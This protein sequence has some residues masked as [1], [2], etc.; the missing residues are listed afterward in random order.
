MPQFDGN[1]ALQVTRELT[2]EAP[3]I[4]VS[5]TIGE[6]RAIDALRAGAADYVLKDNLLRL[7]PAVRRAL[8]D[9][10]VRQDRVRQEE[11][12]ARLDRV[13]GMLSG[14]NELVVRVLDR[15]E[16]L[17]ETC[18]LAVR[19]GGYL[20]AVVYLKTPGT[21]NLAIEAW[22]GDEVLRNALPNPANIQTDVV[23]QIVR[24]GKVFLCIDAENPSIPPRLREAIVGGQLSAVVGLPW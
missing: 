2:P 7:A 3:F 19:A 5:G 14:I 22:S 11:H 1:A 15:N 18:R 9:V 23:G 12:I 8:A 17:N 20:S 4:F 6:E 13:L 10:E 21:A 24:T 16:L